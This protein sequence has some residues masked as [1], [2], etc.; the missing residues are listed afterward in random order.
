MK[1]NW[2]MILLLVVMAA[3]VVFA[4]AIGDG[5]YNGQTTKEYRQMVSAGK[6]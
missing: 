2:K 3:L 6:R 4:V 5:G 1:K